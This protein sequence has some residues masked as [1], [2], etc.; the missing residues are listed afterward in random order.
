MRTY[1]TKTTDSDCISKGKCGRERL[2]L[3]KGL[4]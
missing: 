1:M 3:E 4:E 2:K